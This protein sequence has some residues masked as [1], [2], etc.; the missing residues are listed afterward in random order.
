MVGYSLVL[1]TT[2]D[3]RT[4][5]SVRDAVQGTGARVAV[6]FPPGVMLGW[7]P[8]ELSSTV[9]ALPG[10]KG[11]FTEPV[12]E[13]MLAG[14]DEV[15]LA[16][17]RFFNSVVSGQLR[18]E[19]EEA[20]EAQELRGE[21]ELTPL[22]NDAWDAPPLDVDAYL[23]NLRSVGFDADKG[24]KGLSGLS[25]ALAALGNSDDMIGT[26]TVTLF[27]V[28]SDGSMDPNTYTWTTS[29]VTY[30][31]NSATSG[32]SWW[33]NKAA[34]YGKPLSFTVYY[35]PGTDVRC[36]TGY[37]PIL[38][39]SS[40]APDWIA[41]IMAS[42]GY[43]SGSHLD[44]VRAYDTWARSNYGTDWA[45]SAF[46]EYNPS[47]AS[48]RFTDNYFAWAYFGGYVNLLYR[49]DGW[50]DF[51]G[52]FSHETGHVFWACDEYYQA[53]YG[54]CTSCGLCSHGI[55]N[56]N[57]QYCNSQAVG[58]MMRLQQTDTL[59]CAF[60]PGHLGWLDGPIV[61]Y[62]SHVIHDPTG[63]NNGVV[64]AGESVTMPVTLKNWG[65]PVTNVSAFLSTTDSYITISNNY[66]T[67]SDM[68]LDGK[69]TSNTSYAFTASSGTP[70][71]HV[72]TFTLTI[73]GASYDTTAT[74]T[75]QVGVAPILLV[76]DDGGSSYESYYKAALDANGYTYANWVVKTQG[77]PSLSELN[78][79][80]IV[81]WFTSLQSSVTLTGLDE[82]NLQ[83]YLNAGGTLFF[84]SQDYL[85]ERFE[86]FAQ[87]YLHVQ[88]FIPDVA[89]TS[90]T[91]VS[92]DPISNGLSLTTSYPF[93]N[94]SDDVTP[95]PNAGAILTN[96]TSNPGA[97]RYPA[98]G[99]AAYK[100]VFFAFPFE[101]VAN[102]TAPNNRATVIKRV[103]DWLLAPQDYQPPS[104][105][106][107][108]PNG[109][110]EWEVDTEQQIGWIAGDN[111]T[112]DSVSIY[113][114]TDGGASFPYTIATR[115][116]NDST[117]TWTVPD[118]PS[119]SCVVKVV[120]YDSSLNE[121]EDVS[122]ALFTIAPP[123]D[124]T[125]PSITV[126][127]PNGGEVFYSDSPDTIRWIAS[128]NIGVDSVSIYY[129]INAGATF[130]YTVATGE[131][132]DSVYAWTVPDTPSDS[133]VV[134]IVAYDGS[135]NTAED[136]SDAIF[137]ISSPMGV[138]PIAEVAKFGLLE[139]HPN[140]FNPVT[141]IEFGLDEQARVSLR[142]YDISGKVVRTLVQESMS[143]GRHNATWN[144]EDESGMAVASGIYVCRLEAGS[145]TALRKMV[146]LR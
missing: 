94:Y 137:T 58:C 54:G 72:V 45:F 59:L 113:Y 18:Q 134:K 96:S 75:I 51:N 79:R 50:P 130:P 123:P 133:C 8:P 144:G 44:R 22:I 108:S 106:V 92:G 53:G 1:L 38:H 97:L 32:L 93:Y 110:E 2:D 141:R 63:N 102:G 14:M 132:N 37:E 25:P 48:T 111:A 86:T 4:F 26:V 128:D 83:S 131:A 56:G 43:S 81:I 127:R 114:S 10:V 47:P 117:F 64:D 104:I 52:V 3:A 21:T 57:C 17:V 124:T 143:A 71:A 145:K 13:A 107:T 87:N 35:Y 36:Q 68:A 139:N 78:K 6:A 7:V 12:P 85:T 31:V 40:D 39:S 65:L 105:A 129:S 90:E 125:S 138:N 135:L 140:P 15:T 98:S 119:D 77:S 9:A 112:V 46:I 99:T 116:A 34:R 74:V 118:T 67:Y 61:K 95:G 42:F 60:T 101:A 126:V 29:A 142:I 76:D 16:H 121:T 122:D 115:E 27:F 82:T 89:S 70:P 33:S 88:D 91:G 146:L 109:G 19:M 49:N 55:N 30:A 62:Y 66:S 136:I 100:V 41:E 73:I 20:R 11:V 24:V 84:S 80:E 69:A 120:A 23:E 28:E 103:V 5:A